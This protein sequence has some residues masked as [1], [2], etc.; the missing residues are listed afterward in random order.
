MDE[1]TKVCPF[2]AETIKAKAIVCRYCG[3]D[4]PTGVET[5]P[6]AVEQVTPEQAGF[7]KKEIARYQK[8]GYRVVWQ[9]EKKAQLVKP[10]EFSFWAALL[11][12]LFFGVG[13][14]IYVI[15]YAS[16]KDET[17]YLD[18]V[19]LEAR[20][21]RLETKRASLSD[22]VLRRHQRG[23]RIQLWV[24]SV[25]VVLGAL[26]LVAPLEDYRL[27]A[28][29]PAGIGVLWLFGAATNYR[30]YGG[31]LKRRKAES[32]KEGMSDQARH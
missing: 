18:A 10:K 20:M 31:E 23:A 15:Y 26:I 12:L 32:W 13:L 22:D 11:S 19:D 8:R 30:A 3:R 21:K 28:I 24:A 25:I 27:Y 7:L 16:Q 17:I 2:C 5:A 14:V 29:L 6:G 4:L 1:E 9:D